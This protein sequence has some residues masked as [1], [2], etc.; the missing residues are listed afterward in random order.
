MVD[1]GSVIIFV[2]KFLWYHLNLNHDV[3]CP[4]H[5]VVQVKSF[6]SMHMYLDFTSEMALFIWSFIVVKSDVG[7]LTS[8]GYYIIFPLAVNLVL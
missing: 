8:P 5:L 6:T 7:V 1:S 3:F 4:V 2:H